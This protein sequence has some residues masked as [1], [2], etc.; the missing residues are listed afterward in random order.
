MSLDLDPSVI[1]RDFATDGIPASGPWEPRKVDIRQY[2]S[3]VRQAVIALLADADPGLALPNLLIRASD[4]GAGT[5]NAIQATT[6]LP[7]PAGDAGALIALNI[8][9]ENTGSPVTVAFN[10][11]SVLTVKSNSGNDIT[12]GGLATGMVVLGVVFA[13]TF[14]LFSDQSSAAILAA[15]EAAA[16]EAA[17]ARDQ[18]VA[19]A[20]TVSAPKAT[21]ALV[22]ADAPALDPEY[23]DVSYRDASYQRGSGALYRKVNSEPSHAG[24]VQNAN[25]TW[26]EIAAPVLLPEM[27]GAVGDWNGSAGTNNLTALTNL[28]AVSAAQN[29]SVRLSSG[30]SYYTSAAVATN[31]DYVNIDG[32]FSARIITDATTGAIL[33]VGTGRAVATTKTLSANA[34]IGTKVLTFADTTGIQAGDIAIMKSSKAWYND[35][36]TDGD[37]SSG[38]FSTTQ[39]GGAFTATLA[40]GFTVSNPAL[41][42]G[43]EITFL[44]GPNAGLARVVTGYDDSTKVIN[45][46]PGLPT[47]LGAGVTYRFPEA[48]K[49]QTVRVGRVISGTQIEL[50][51]ALADGY[52]VQDGTAVN[53]KERVQVEFFR[54]YEPVIRGFTMEGPGVS[55]DNFGLLLHRAA[56]PQVELK[57]KGV[58]RAGAQV[59]RCWGG[60]IYMIAE[61]ITDEFTGYGTQIS[62]SAKVAINGRGWN[63]RRLFDV[64]GITPSD[65]C[66]I[67]GCVVDGGGLQEDGSA[68]YPVGSVSNSGIGTHGPARNTI[69][70]E[71]R[72]A[73]V[74]YGIFERGRGAIIRDNEFGPGVKYPTYHSFGGRIEFY[75]NVIDPMIFATPGATGPEETDGFGGVVQDAYAECLL[76]LGANLTQNQPDSAVI[77]RDNI[78]RVRRNIV[79]AQTTGGAGVVL[80]NV[81]VSDNDVEFFPSS[82]SDALAVY[83]KFAGSSSATVSLRGGQHGPN[84]M[85]TA[86]ANTQ[87][88][89]YG[90]EFAIS[91]SA[92]IPMRFGPSRWSIRLG[93]DT[94]A[95]IPVSQVG[96]DRILVAISVEE[97]ATY[98][99]MGWLTRDS[100]AHI[101]IAGG[102]GPNT[103]VLAAAPTGTSGTDG[104]MQ[105]HFGG[106][107][108]TI[109]NRLGGTRTFNVEV[110]SMG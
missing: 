15:V 8:F 27:L 38:A 82:P 85:R 64:S 10:G 77:V 14:R 23:Y 92:S 32:D 83:G 63:N 79:Q 72:F 7:V 107:K 61:N 2:E 29:V 52:H 62:M 109:G 42:V 54:P 9:E 57:V 93:D 80:D 28:L 4:T 45:F 55:A 90:A 87:P 104:N 36:R 66:R 78:A 74:E 1:W 12:A 13:T 51:D 33:S 101:Q 91:A 89:L 95:F 56:S 68:Y 30:R 88:I 105:L 106:G 34:R 84:R 24:K 94:A 3:A 65:S 67:H 21:L 25:G 19:A 70:E 41:M 37:I 60:D 39:A 53:V 31:A 47:S 73:N 46:T 102:A 59:S 99:F 17:A 108:L 40:A 100:T 16:G 76:V 71:N 97:T 11:G 110:F 20:A 49:G 48:F 6:N 75:D 103:Q 43:K 44:S 86:A 96:R 58:R 26:Y 35:P 18:A 22:E 5:P 81:S 69:Y 50:V 98:Y